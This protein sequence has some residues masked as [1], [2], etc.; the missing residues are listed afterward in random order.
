MS[1]NNDIYEKIGLTV[2]EA[3][4][5]WDYDFVNEMNDFTSTEVV[6]KE[7]IS[8]D[9][10]SVVQKVYLTW[11]YAYTLEKRKETRY[12]EDDAW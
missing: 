9:E 6:L 5:C 4:K 1:K 10:L 7:I 8:D 3:N 2:E 12:I 11:I